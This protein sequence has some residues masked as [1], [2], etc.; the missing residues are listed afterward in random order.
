MYILSNTMRLMRPTSPPLIWRQPHMISAV[1][2][3]LIPAF[4]DHCALHVFNFGDLASARPSCPIRIASDLRSIR[5]ASA[6][7]PQGPRASVQ[8]QRPCEPLVMRRSCSTTEM[9]RVLRRSLRPSCLGTLSD[10]TSSEPLSNH[11]SIR[12]GLPASLHDPGA[13]LSADATAFLS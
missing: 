11:Q 2:L 3:G 10:T 7:T 8:L 12:L 5:L 1:H 13:S 4:A 9:L 6:S